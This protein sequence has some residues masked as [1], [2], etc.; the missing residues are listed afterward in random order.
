MTPR[1]FAEHATEAGAFGTRAADMFPTMAAAKTAHALGATLADRDGILR[2]IARRRSPAGGVGAQPGQPSDAWTTCYAIDSLW[3]AGLPIPSWLPDFLLSLHEDGGGFAMAPGQ[4][5]ETWSTAFSIIGLAQSGVPIPAPDA[6]LAWFAAVLLATGGFTW[7]PEWVDR[8][9]PDVRATAFV[10]R[11]L[12]AAGLLREF[13]AIVNLDP[14]V[15]FLRAAQAADGAFRLDNRHPP[16]LWGTGEAVLTLQTLGSTPRDPD[17]CLSF[18]AGMRGSDGGYRRGPDYPEVSD[19]WAT[20]HGVRVRL[21]LGDVPGD[22]ERTSL[23]VF[24]ESCAVP[25]GAFTYR[26]PDQASDVLTTS[27]AALA[28]DAGEGA[29]R[30]LAACRMPGEGGVAYMPARGSEAR[31]TLWT[32]TAQTRAGRLAGED[33]LAA[34]A[35]AAQNPDGGFGPW[36]GRASN[37]V[38]TNSVVEALVLA[39]YDLADVIDV[40]AAGTWITTAMASHPVGSPA[41]DL[42]ALSALL[43]A[44]RALGVVLDTRPVR[45]A[46]ATHRRGAAWCRTSAAVPDLLTTY[47]ALTAHQT[48]GDLERVLPAA[49]A[50]VRRLPSDAA[51]TAWSEL[52]NAGAGPLPT[53]LAVLIVAA[54]DRG[55]RLPNLTL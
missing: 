25:G 45:A 50:W 24:I 44:G 47:V 23:M 11:A 26:P 28:G 16:C 12:A 32:M 19:V 21:A 1:A 13:T 41:A 8:G 10:I 20:M 51:G 54:A 38:S 27:A 40:A 30:F 17:A 7:S 46:L 15:D 18:V 55:E 42:V 29:L 3:H 35:H 14:T 22:I 34:W 4:R 39:G 49:A 33:G 6:S 36:E 53:A 43:C 31:A 48:L 9:R 52:T 5:P 37:A 2:A